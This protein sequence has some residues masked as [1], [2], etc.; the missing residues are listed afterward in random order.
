MG[1][2]KNSRARR[3]PGSKPLHHCRGRP[4][5][6]PLVILRAAKSSAGLSVRAGK[7]TKDARR[8]A[9]QRGLNGNESDNKF[10]IGSTAVPSCGLGGWLGEH[11]EPQDPRWLRT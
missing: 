8:A 1:G 3:Q 7:D 9:C 10:G 2:K 11:R 5:L 4:V 6:H